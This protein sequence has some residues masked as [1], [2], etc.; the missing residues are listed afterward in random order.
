MR[1]IITISLILISVLLIEFY[2]PQVIIIVAVLLGSFYNIFYSFISKDNNSPMMMLLFSTGYI[3]GAFLIIAITIQ[4]LRLG[5]V[6]TPYLPGDGASYYYSAKIAVQ[7]GDILFATRR[8]NYVGYPLVLS[9][10][11]KFFGLHLVYGLLASFLTLFFNIIIIAKIS[12]IFTNEKKVYFYAFLLTI[13]TSQF[14]ATGFMLLKDAFIILGTS[15]SFYASVNNK[16]KGNL[17]LNILLLGLSIVIFALFRMTYIWVPL[18]IFL[19][20]NFKMNAKSILMVPV[21]IALL[22]LGYNLGDQLKVKERTTEDQV[23]LVLSNEIITGRLQKDEKSVMT[24]LVSGYNN[25]S[26][27]KQVIY[28]P[29]TFSI[30]Y[31][32][33]FNFYD[34]SGSF[35]H[36]YKLISKNYNL[37]WFLFVGPVFLFSIFIVL[38]KKINVQWDVKIIFLVG[39]FMYLIPAFIFSGAIPRYAFAFFPL[40]VPMMSLIYLS[41]KN[42]NKIRSL[43][44]SFMLVY[45]SVAMLALILYLAYKFI[46]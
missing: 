45:Y 25:W 17:T 41:T 34:Y 2:E 29:V 33:P 7:S 38:F 36:S 28:L 13:L 8:L 32:T 4:S 24:A 39:L 42:N 43:W 14:V 20:L 11:F 6:E 10:I 1:G 18:A 9:Y 35:K 21:I 15:L 31:S 22:V 30:Q 12:Y 19:I 16:Y 27:T 37:L 40:M 5:S 44:L 3:L 23:D 26:F 46:L